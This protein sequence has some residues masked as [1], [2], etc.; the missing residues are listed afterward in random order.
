MKR[1]IA[2]RIAALA[3][4]LVLAGSLVP[5]AWAA[6]GEPEGGGQLTGVTVTPSN[7]SMKV[8]ERASVRASAAGLSQDQMKDARIE[9]S[10]ENNDPERVRIASGRDSWTVE[11]EAVNTAET[12][13]TDP[14]TLVATVTCQGGAERD[15]CAITVVPDQP[16]GLRI[17]PEGDQELEPGETLQLRAEIT[18]ADQAEPVTWSSSDPDAAEVDRDTGLVTAG[19]EPGRT[20]ITA[21]SQSG[22]TDSCEAAV[23][24]IVLP[25]NLIMRENENQRLIPEV[26]GA[27]LEREDAAWTSSD[28][29]IL[30]VDN[31]Y[32]YPVSVGEATVTAEI[33]AGGRLYTASCQVTV[34]A[35]TA[36]VI[37]AAAGAGDPLRF[38]E[39]QRE[40]ERECRSV[41][42]SSLDY[43]G[44]LWVNTRQGTLY[45]RY[46]SEGDT[47]AGV[48]TSENY[49]ADPSAS[50]MGLGDVAFV[51]KGD[52][53]GTA[54]IS[55]TGYARDGGSFQGT[56]EVEV[57]ETE[58]IE[59]AASADKAVQF[60]PDD[61]NRVCRNRT[62]RDLSYV[63]FSHPDSGKG[64][65]YYRY[66][67]QANPGSEVDP[68]KEYK[69]SGTPSLSDVYFVPEGGSG[70]AVIS[71]TGYNVYGDSFRGRITIRISEAS[72]RGDLNYSIAQGGRLNLDESDFNDLA[73]RITGYALDYVQF[74]L[75]ASS[76]GTLYYNYTGNGSYDSRVT[77]GR[78]YYRSSSPY[79]RRVTFVADRDFS[80]TAEIDF[81]AWDTK[82]N[83]FAGTVEVAVGRGGK[84]DI[85]YSV[86]QNGKVTLDDNDFNALCRELTGSTLDH[87]SFD[88][89]PAAQG[90]LYYRYDNGD[91]DSKVTSSK[92]YYRSGSPYLDQVTFVPARNFSGVVSIPFTGR[93]TNGEDFSGQ[94][95]IG[96]DTGSDLIEYRVKPNSFVTF[97]DGD[98]DDLCQEMTGSRLR[99]VRFELP[100]SSKGTLY[101]GYDDGDY[102]SKVTES[103]SYYRGTDPYL[104]RVCF[105]PAE[106]VFG[107][108][109]LEF[110]GWSTDGGKFEG[111]VRIT[112]EE[113]KGPSVITYATDGRPL[114]FYARDF[115]EA[116]EDRGMGGLAYVRF[117]TPS[118]SVGRLYFQYQGAGESNT[119]VRMTTSYY[120]AK[121][122]GISEITFVPKVGYQGT[123][124][125]SYTGWDTKGNEYRGRIQISVRPATASRY[126]W[127]MSSFEWAVPAVDLLYENGVVHGTG[128]GTYSPG[129]QITRG[130][131]VLM[132]CQAFQLSGQGKAGFWDVPRDSYYAQA[133]MTAQALGITGG[134]PD[135]GF[136]PGSPVTRQD[137]AVF[138]MK[139]MQ[140]DGWSL[141][142]GN[143]QMLSRFRDESSIS[144]YARS[145]MAVMVEYG[146][147]SGTAD[148]TISPQKAITRAEMAVML[149]NALTL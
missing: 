24:G 100:S 4:A 148:Q 42:G 49:Y 131:Y 25:E 90:T 32:L 20:K 80:G 140:A 46:N 5:G 17:T 113:P 45:Y 94:L 136:H 87:V 58:E 111:T 57:E 9:W 63:E 134:Y 70:Q 64:T 38:D 50:Q 88:P 34:E 108:V 115:Q 125:I 10:L 15:T 119:E 82:G 114:S 30:K 112:V 120:P 123:A 26:Y 116:C 145:A 65:L 51:P 74:E 56:I 2:N 99:Y 72:G 29:R 16:A 21:R 83:R 1:S 84:G 117:D 98:F 8:G 133:V 6:E 68:S 104:D 129:Q 96:V 19:R 135:G 75:P 146:V 53:S 18:P 44:G 106:G 101:Y 139:A 121:S 124:S 3:L 60:D 93:G 142:S 52:F 7:L 73:K 107:A 27:A 77:E 11:V 54:V 59:Y 14:V 66:I 48:G 95:E 41:L 23:R 79:L 85:R 127:D 102:D 78:S 37:T 81:N 137:A 147:L 109:D 55:Y 67:S 61:F 92:C 91:Y 144:A 71:Y 130:D 86:H 31:G 132:L 12:T 33:R 13:E 36:D 110:T 138:L 143:E 149:A 97:D 22:L 128:N 141:G 35:N 103:K 122:P 43:V 39:I 105:V 62:G 76:E 118:S 40:L 47:G 28:E 69:R 126:F 89:P